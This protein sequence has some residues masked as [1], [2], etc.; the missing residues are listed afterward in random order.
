MIGPAIVAIGG[1]VIALLAGRALPPKSEVVLL[2]QADGSP[3]AVVVQ[4]GA[5]SQIL[6]IPYQ[7]T[8]VTL[9]Q[10]PVLDSVDA[11]TVAKTYPALFS[12][13]P[14]APEQ[15]TVYFQPG[16]LRLTPASEADLAKIVA[17]A[18]QRAGADILVTGHTD[19]Q[20]SDSD[21]DALSLKRAELVRQMLLQN[22]QSVKAELIEA[23][24]R[25]KRQLAIPTADGVA[26]AR[27]RRV[28]IV[29]R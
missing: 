26:E 6:S 17:A 1:L 2:P 25:G 11:A 19:A 14:P 18:L 13:M 27:N 28:E 3:S 4:S 12:A 23:T 8:S 9:G 24:G 10:P 21:N 22:P 5:V 29:L 16:G 20:G 15:F 7:R